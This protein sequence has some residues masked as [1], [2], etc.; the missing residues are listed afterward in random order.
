VNNDRSLY[1]EALK[2]GHSYSWDQR[3]NEAINE[4]QR[5]IDH[6]PDEPAP[7]AGL[8]M[9]YFEEGD[10]EQSLSNY[11]L[12]ARYS[13][14]E[15]IYLK[16][17]ADVQERLGHLHDAGQTYMAIGEI[18]LRR[19]K[20]DEAV[21]NWLR[22]VR[23]EPNLISGHQRL[24]AVYKRQGLTQNAVREYLAIA[25]IYS[26]RGEKGKALKACQ[27]ALEL[28]PRNPDVITAM[29]LV[30]QGEALISED[31]EDLP[32]PAPE[33]IPISGIVERAVTALEA[34]RRGIT[35]IDSADTAR[36]PVESAQ[37]IALEQLAKGIFNSLDIDSEESILQQDGISAL[38]RDALISQ[39]LDFQTRGMVTEAVSCFE[40]ALDGDVTNRAANFCLGI[41]YQ[42]Q[43]RLEKAIGQFQLSKEDELFSLASHYAIGDC[44]RAVN[45]TRLAIQNFVTVLKIIDLGMASSGET[46][47]VI[48]LYDYLASDLLSS[49]DP[50]KSANF[51]DA[52]LAFLGKLGWQESVRTSRDRLDDLSYDG[53]VFILGDILTAGSTQVLESLHLSQQ[54]AKRGKYDTAVEEAYRAIQLSPDFLP[55]HLQLAQIMADQDRVD[56]AVK[57]F[58]MIGDTYNV[59]GDLKSAVDAYEKALELSPSDTET[60]TQLIDLLLRNQQLEKAIEHA[61]T[62]G[63]TYY[64]LAQVDMARQAYVE[65]LTFT[66]QLPEGQH[67]RPE[68]L[69]RIADIDMQRLDW[70][71]AIAAYSELSKSNPEDEQAALTLVELFFK[72]NQTDLALGWLDQFFIT[73]VRNR[74]GARIPTLLAEL[75]EQRPGEPGLVDRLA[76]L[77]IK[78]ERI[79]DAIQIY[80]RLGEHQLE[81]NDRS[82]AA[83]TIEMILELNPEDA[84]PYQQ[85]LEQLREGTP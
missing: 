38:E 43:S 22:A 39:A 35:G 84:E 81:S 79:E 74:K 11:K 82:G 8:G 57:K 64:S 66:A 83:R 51:I 19:R 73:L 77:Y 36:N 28:E 25:R 1:E 29:E 75:V 45:K 76:R 50:R 10:L 26:F 67:F 59:R 71:E 37:K 31:E 24:A 30:E 32:A 53:Q 48:E 72:V 60:R 18:Q 56:N 47:R 14:G 34:N 54:Y 80:D 69:R 62:L 33:E 13:R 6:I 58:V 55:S 2:Q 70:K 44:Y 7:Y 46:E 16:H 68:L 49:G 42:S 78:N 21:G 40:R 23:L 52:L 12:A 85:L 9:A 3:W 41:L 17:V 5:A 61:I 65:A 27:L 4:F 20:L 15:M 63:E